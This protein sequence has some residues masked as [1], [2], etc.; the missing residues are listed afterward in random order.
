MNWLAW[1]RIS[2]GV[3]WCYLSA[4]IMFPTD[5][6]G[7]VLG[8]GTGILFWPVIF[9]W[10]FAGRKKPRNWATTTWVFLIFALL[11]PVIVRGPYYPFFSG[12]LV[13]VLIAY[14]VYRVGSLLKRKKSN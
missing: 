1:L 9:A 8:A 13:L 14:L 5:P 11:W 6:L 2:I 12:G 4:A 10:L 7:A 3:L